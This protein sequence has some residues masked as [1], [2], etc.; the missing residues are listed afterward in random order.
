MIEPKRD[1]RR[2][3]RLPLHAA[4]DAGDHVHRHLVDVL[5][6]MHDRLA[7]ARALP[8]AR[9]AALEIRRG[10]RAPQLAERR[11]LLRV[12]DDDEVPVLRVARG[13]RLL[14]EAEALLEHLALD[15]TREVEPLAHGAGGRESSSGVSSRSTGRSS[16]SARRSARDRDRHAG[17]DADDQPAH[18]RVGEA[19]AAVGDGG[20]GDAAD[21]RRVRAGRSG[22]GPPANSCRTLERALRASANGAPTSVGRKAIDSSTKNSPD[23]VGVDGLPTTALKTRTARPP[24]RRSRPGETVS[25]TMCQPVNEPAVAPGWIHPVCPFGRPGSL[26]FSQ[27]PLLPEHRQHGPLVSDRRR[28]RHEPER[29]RADARLR[30]GLVRAEQRDELLARPHGRRLDSRRRACPPRSVRRRRAHATR[31]RAGADGARSCS[32]N[33]CSTRFNR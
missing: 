23:G 2:A 9:P 32:V 13:R 15:R 6:E 24:S 3:R 1:G 14:R 26:T 11:A 7:D 25:T 22:P 8:L 28:R 20:A 18:R 33:R 12:G 10:D 5:G 16:Q 31:R 17:A 27:R 29:R 21:V 30:A 19:H 4:L